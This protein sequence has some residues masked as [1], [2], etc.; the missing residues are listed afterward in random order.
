MLVHGVEA[1]EI[2]LGF[3]SMGEADSY[4]KIK[5]RAEIM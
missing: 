3:I 1:I 2:T 4:N 5:D